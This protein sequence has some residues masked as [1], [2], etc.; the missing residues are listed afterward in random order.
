MEQKIIEPS[1]FVKFSAI[2]QGMLKSAITK[3]SPTT[4][5]L[6]TLKKSIIMM[7]N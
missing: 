5:I 6:R 1:R 2:K 7:S 4:R 3:I